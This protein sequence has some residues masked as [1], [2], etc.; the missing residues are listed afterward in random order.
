M[1]QK[2]DG[3]KN[4]VAT[5]YW[6]AYLSQMKPCNVKA[7]ENGIGKDETIRSIDFELDI[8][9]RLRAFSMN[10]GV[11]LSSIFHF[12]WALI[13]RHLTG[14][15]EVCF[16]Y[17]A[18]GRPDLPIE[19]EGATDAN[20]DISISRVKLMATAHLKQVVDTIAADMAAG[21]K[22]QPCPMEDI[23]SA[24]QFSAH[25]PF[26]TLLFVA[27]LGGGGDE[28]MQHLLSAKMGGH[29]MEKACDENLDVRSCEARRIITY[30]ELQYDVTMCIRTSKGDMRALLEYRTSIMS[31]EVAAKVVEIFCRTLLH[32]V[33]EPLKT[34][35]GLDPCSEN[36]LSQ[37]MVS[38]ENGSN[39]NARDTVVAPILQQIDFDRI[40]YH[41]KLNM[42]SLEHAAVTRMD[43][44]ADRELIAF[45][46]F[47]DD[48]YME[49]DE[50]CLFPVSDT[51]QS[52]LAAL[53]TTI[54]KSFPSYMRPTIYVPLWSMPFNAS[55]MADQE[56]LKA[57][58]SQLSEEEL[59]QCISAEL[60]LSM[61]EV[62]DDHSPS[63]SIEKRLQQLWEADVAANSVSLQPQ[64]NFFSLG[65]DSLAA[66]RLAAAARDAGISLTVA[67]IF[68]QAT[69]AGMS[70]VAGVLDLDTRLAIEPFALL[71]DIG[72]PKSLVEEVAILANIAP[73]LIQDLYPTTALQEGFMALTNKDPGAY[74]AQMAYVLPENIDLP[75]FQSAWQSMLD[76][77]QTLRTR[78]VSTKASITLQAV[79]QDEIVWRTAASLE[80]YLSK[81]KLMPIEYGAPLTRYAIINAG[82]ERYFV[83]TV[84]HSVYDGWSLPMILNKVEK[85]YVDGPA[86]V[87]APE[88]PFNSFIK[89]L[90]D[91]D[92][93]A[94]DAF[95]ES[96]LAGATHNNFLQL[97][98]IVKEERDYR[99]ID[100]TID[101]SQEKGSRTTMSTMV[102]AAWALVIGRYSES[103]DVVFGATLTGRNAPVSG[104]ETMIGP[105]ITTVPVRVCLNRE[106]RIADFLD[107]V[108][109]QATRMI[110]F[111]HTGLQNIQRIS[112]DTRNA[113]NFQNLLIIQPLVEGDDQ[114]CLLDLKTVAVDP[115]GFHSYALTMECKL[116][117]DT[118]EISVDF[119][120]RVI[121]QDQMNRMIFQF[122]H[123]MRQL[124]AEVDDS[125]VGSVSI[126]SPEDKK[127]LQA[128]NSTLPEMLD[129]C[130]HEA[131]G[132]QALARPNSPAVC[133]WDANFTYEE[134]D[135]RSTLL[136]HHLM[137]L[138]VG[139]DTIVP[140]CFQKSAWTIVAIL[141]I[142]KAG[143]AFVPLDSS[144]PEERLR[145]IIEDVGAKVVLTTP[146]HVN[147]FK[148]MVDQIVAFTPAIFKQI[149]KACDIVHLNVRSD[150]LA[151]VV[152]TSGS[153]GRPKGI[154][155]RHAAVCTS[156][157]S[158][159]TALNLGPSSR[160]LQFAAYTFDVSLIDIFTTLM[161]GGC[162][163][164]PSEHDRINDLSGVINKMEANWACITP[165][166]A[167]LLKPADIPSMKTLVLA[168]EAVT[169]EVLNTWADAVDLYNCYG[170]TECSA[171]SLKSNVAISDNPANIG[172][173]LG[174]FTWIVEQAGEAQLTPIGCVG[175]LWIEGPSLA[176]GYFKDEAKTAAAFVENPPWLEVVGS[177]ESRRVYGT[178]D[179]VRY[180][181]DGT[182]ELLGRKDTQV[183][184]HGQRVELGEIEHQIKLALSGLTQVAVEMTSMAGRSN[185][186]ALAAFLCFGEKHDD[187]ES[188]TTYIEL[189][190][191]ETMRSAMLGLE[192]ILA[193]SL[194]SIMIP[195]LFIPMKKM[196][197]TVSGKLD[198]KKLRSLASILTEEQVAQYSLAAAEKRAPGTDMEKELQMLWSVV[199]EIP[200]DM[201]GANDSFFRLGG[202]SVRAMRLVAAARAAGFS[203]TVSA[204]FRQPTLIE[205]STIAKTVNDQV[206][207]RLEPFTL[208]GDASP[209]HG[210][211]KEVAVQCNV[212]LERVLDVYPCT[213]LQEGLMMLS[214]KLPGAYVNQMVF[215]LPPSLDV[216][217]FQ[218]AWKATALS[219]DILRTRLIYTEDSRSLQAI[220]EAE[221]PWISAQSLQE[222]LKKDNL[223]QVEYGGPLAR[224][225]IVDDGHDLH[226]RYFVWT[227][228]HAIYDGWTVPLTLEKVAQRY[229]GEVK[230]SPTTEVPFNS[231]IKYLMNVD[232]TASDAFW[233]SEL[234]GAT[235]SNFL[236]RSSAMDEIQVDSRLGYSIQV[237]PQ[238]GSGITMSTI[239]RAAWA[240]VIARYSE[241][242]D[243]VFGATLTGRN[244]PVAGI[245]T[246]IGPAITTVPVRVLMNR[247]QTVW[248][249][250]VDIQ[251]RATRMIPFEHTGL[252]NIQR[253]SSD[254]HN[255]CNFQNLLVVHPPNGAKGENGPLGLQ[256]MVRSGKGFYTYAMVVECG[257]DTDNIDIRV[258]Y[259]A[260]AISES[261]M[262]QMLNQFEHVIR[263]LTRDSKDGLLGNVDV[264]S[265]Q[266]R[267]QIL[268][269]NSAKYTRLEMCVH[270]VVAQQVL[271]RPE[272]AA[273]CSWDGEFTYRELDE[274]S[275]RLAYH[276]VGV[277]VG[278]EVMVPLCFEKSAWTIVSM[279]AVL[280]AGGACVSL[281]PSHPLGRL[282][283]VINDVAAK[284][285]LVAPVTASIFAPLL[286][287]LL[288]IDSSFLAKLPTTHG[289]TLPTDV[290][291][292]N[293][294]FVIFTSGSTG[295][296]KGVILEHASICTSVEA[297]GSVL[298]IGPESRVLQ[299]AAHVF[300]ISIQDI[301]TTLM[302]G[303]CVCVPS[304]HDRVN[305]L[306]S[307][308][309]QMGVNFACIT[310]TVASLLRPSD[311]PTLRTLT[312][313]GEAVTK[314]V[315][316]IW[317]GL[318]SLNNCY[319]P[320]ESTIYCAWNGLVGKGGMPANIGRGLASHLWVVEVADHDRLAP[321]G[322]VGELLVEGPL[323][324]RGY[325]NDAEKTASSFIHDPV[326]AQDG[327]SGSRRMYKTGDLVRYNTNGTLDYL[328]RKDSQVKVH[329][330]RLELGEVEYHLTSDNQVENAM[331]ILPSRGHCRE[332]LVAVIALHNFTNISESSQ[333][334]TE[335]DA[336]RIVSD[337]KKVAALQLSRLEEHLARQLPAYMLPALWIVVEVIP[338]NTS[339]KLDRARVAQWVEDLDEET[340]RQI[341][342]SE[343]EPAVGPTT[344]MDRRLQVVLSRVLNL[345][346]EHIPLNRSFLSLGGDSITAM[347]VVSRGRTDGFALRVQDI[348]KSKTLSQLALL[349]T[350]SGP[351]SVSK[352]DEVDKIFGLSPMQQMYFEMV[353]DKVVQ[354]NQS[355]F[356][357][358]T[359][360]IQAQ[361]M[362]QAVDTVVR[363][364]S[365]LRARFGRTQDDQ[366]SQT[367]TKDVAES[368]QFQFH[369]VAMREDVTAIMTHSQAGLDVEKGPV[370]SFDM[371]NVA[372]DGQLLFVVAHHLVIDLVS[373]RVILQDMEE[374]LESGT[375]SAEKPFPFQAWVKLQSDYAQQHL[376]PKSV[377]PFNV[378]PADY[379]YW[380]LTD[381]PV[382][383]GDG[384][385]ET[386]TLEVETSDTLLGK[387]HEALGTE[388]V[389]VFIAALLHSF[390]QTFE[391]RASP[392]IFSEGHG[393]E[394][395]DKDIDLSDTVGWFTTIFPLYV[396]VNGKGDIVD[397]VRRTKDIRRSL[398]ENG[399]PY[400]ASRYLN[401]EGIEAFKHHWPM[402]IVFNYLGQYQQL[403][404]SDG[405]M[406]KEPFIG[407]D[408]MLNASRQMPRLA[409]MEVSVVIVKGCVQFEFLYSRKMRH[410]ARALD[411]MKLYKQTLEDVA[412]RLS[413][414]EPEH[415][416]SDFPLL[417]LTYPGLHK[418]RDERLREVGVASFIDV[419][420]VYP[421][422]PMQEGLLLSQ[423]RMSGSYEV[424]FMFEVTPSQA[425]APLDVEKLVMAWQQV[426]D[427]HAILRTVFVDSVS[428]D[429]LFDQIVLKSVLARA[430]RQYSMGNDAAALTALQALKP[431]DRR[432]I[433]PPHQ[434]VVCRAD[435]GKVFCKLEISHAIIDAASMVVVV[436]ELSLAYEG[437]LGT[438]A[439]PLYSEYVRYLQ[440][441]PLDLA[442]NYWRE[443]LID[444]E[445]C[446]FP[447]L[448]SADDLVK[449]LRS[450]Q[451]PLL[452]PADALRTFCETNFVTVANVV[453]AVWGLVLRCYTGSDQ[454]CFG[455]LASG[456]DAAVQGIE[457]A[458][459]PFI[460]MLI[461]RIDF[462]GTA[463]VGQLVE[464]VQAGYLAGLEYQHC[465]LA[466]MQHG[467]NLSGRPLFNTLMSIH[468]PS[469][470]ALPEGGDEV[471]AVSFNSLG[472]RDPTEVS[473]TN[474][475]SQTL[476][477]NNNDSTTLPSMWQLQ[478]GTQKS[479]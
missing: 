448:H 136:A 470:S 461:C 306:A 277:G 245:E 265:V 182:M 35:A 222:Y 184:L 285:I 190:M 321:V 91:I 429:G 54:G 52:D 2:T 242:D 237:S 74:V 385:S 55:G 255:A 357:R 332:Q 325:L 17:L 220:I 452:L 433:G 426:V 86:T 441:K 310:P 124:E 87:E 212:G 97:P 474:S 271:S 123:V 20:A 60:S 232:G 244:A 131:I 25:A 197:M 274:L 475:E 369:R 160:T 342:D 206:D 7:T 328:G 80:E 22:H 451:V 450:I 331:V 270:D 163:C 327:E 68:G 61:P 291:P 337:D 69:F 469:Q 408:F 372:G 467:L 308:I 202:D 260:T 42:P 371:I 223:L 404:R 48:L 179:L 11:T 103:D 355:F 278:P 125:K 290:H 151:F 210:L 239:V 261:Q 347:Q 231:F 201:I 192:T 195:S 292:A 373:W 82:Q 405:L 296:P 380:G 6:T 226:E 478:T 351:S 336:L 155:M 10:H 366:W 402:E 146:P 411:W 397:I 133:A 322:C 268:A 403:E 427:R 79:L 229:T 256:S 119:D 150:S 106:Q 100:Y 26:N 390:T 108:Q 116:G 198:R 118:T 217:R 176:S 185:S 445:P 141:A 168:G 191:P 314:K 466:Q 358:L 157:I 376:A 349:A 280:K 393:R 27:Q 23:E 21:S 164:V 113:C 334:L 455:Y 121:S 421:C 395:W 33:E 162:V 204:I 115:K 311:A 417:S 409:P 101:I 276:L 248:S 303:G 173:P 58:F 228:H 360:E 281:D 63:L 381:Q 175:E 413:H 352:E 289:N 401:T 312:L 464:Q 434:L 167:C 318:D 30:R 424:Q 45:I 18:A 72:E 297:H 154:L 3:A 32:L 253:L 447:L 105:A 84:H 142:L 219:T 16:G 221:I 29:N 283:G 200:L 284:V 178:G 24:A 368:Y 224:Y 218:E 324:A 301:F 364:H 251:E 422:S 299:F 13:L 269:W 149:P 414:M 359:R 134:L 166:V 132:Q 431:M 384:V 28:E 378:P 57:L 9:P 8:A 78:I 34:I 444:I 92:T 415:T 343:G 346:V 183:K 170:P 47:T 5:D 73:H 172:R 214:N 90:A 412:K 263:Q 213:P 37:V 126:F 259:A 435:S 12:A 196:P 247:E 293:A 95:W 300:D 438:G 363:Q 148:G 477:A 177:K 302:R 49:D 50:H 436:R 257:L 205:M 370:V 341:V 304:E 129:T 416:L 313:A 209:A 128:W 262:Q 203:I 65:G 354:F 233:K 159:G 383:Y 288:V 335:N 254:A 319:G 419:E 56:K 40:E 180:S 238:K 83:W 70:R 19:S 76:I 102:R 1:S 344:T 15:N 286:Q 107:D 67:D 462:L 428:E 122:V 165:T 379:E 392:T 446:H 44:P 207:I 329:G 345:D 339:R 287:D 396:P 348:L 439:G 315:A 457:D 418:L 147:L 38:D 459:G 137:G 473:N 264:C 298:R 14:S 305:D 454:V 374:I 117:K 406:R 208:L 249:F 62:S 181:H 104:I 362:A 235:S 4:M 367:I 333:Q 156:S 476:H 449:E 186:E 382:L 423:S 41:L 138:G 241:S 468:R 66:M 81:D 53:Q 240:I 294:A 109:E 309:N 211:L 88:V 350:A 465:S 456:R 377:L 174:S 230:M 99:K 77:T 353:G 361:H 243:V 158:H 236:Q 96:E 188:S 432:E 330:Q 443:Y 36:G 43:V 225:A 120:A 139:P 375:L 391:D 320:A 89:Y 460:N 272:A 111:E 307:T 246:M 410:Q 388:P 110:P 187:E 425:S 39:E 161:L 356:L 98:A 442:M 316:D 199:L 317:E 93:N 437:K 152:F 365:M 400:F 387:C 215:R 114:H 398:P 273:I 64:D 282:E 266:D 193:K 275:S 227:A 338:L 407:G 171:C 112:S 51:L 394:G 75:L 94:S 46:C 463:R 145:G 194:P 420:D 85:L 59:S 252:Q 389:D 169:Q 458:I 135:E 479:L 140:I 143:A 267:N 323:L 386:F 472:G 399:W 153:T 31:E 258:D 234:A 71:A 295:K 326:W 453:Q 340:H 189:S 144:H 279:L 430:V 471:P 127:E 130:V 440:A 216:S 250:L